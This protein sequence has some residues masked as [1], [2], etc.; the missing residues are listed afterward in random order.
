MQFHVRGV[1]PAMVTPFREEDLQI[2][3]GVLDQLCDFLIDRGVGGIFALGSTGE[4][5]LLSMD[6][7]RHAAERVL[8]HVSGRAPVIVNCGHVTT[9]GTIELAQHAA[10]AGA[11]AVAAVFPF[12]YAISAE[13]AMD[14]FRAVAH[15]VPDTPLFA[16]YYGRALQPEQTQMLRK[17]APNVV[18]LKNAVG[19][20]GVLL[21]H[22]EL[23]G[24]D[25]CILEGSEH[26]AFGALTLGADGLVSGIGSAFPEPF[27]KLCRLVQAGDYEEA[28]KTQG[29][30]LK[31]AQLFYGSNPWGRIKKSLQLRGIDVGPPRAPIVAC[32]PQETEELT[33][34]L[35]DLGLL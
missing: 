35:Q 17:S 31:L 34:A 9:R 18:G 28:R 11:D 8:A 29:L 2:D 21:G 4:A 3:L 15:A 16:Y 10:A 5:V 25:F 24:E 33:C 22:V 1:F 32:G 19:D 23:L 14:H 27:V 12:Y 7:R 13:A 30:I 20:Y 26:L 6:E